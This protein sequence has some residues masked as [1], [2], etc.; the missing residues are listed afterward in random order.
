MPLGLGEV[1]LR[2]FLPEHLHDVLLRE[3]FEAG[4]KNQFIGVLI[5][6][7]DFFELALALQVR[8]VFEAGD[9]DGPILVEFFLQQFPL[10]FFLDSLLPF[11][12][13]FLLAFLFLFGLGV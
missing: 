3:V 13:Q 9:V 1:L 6:G 4:G 12:L 10:H 7:G 11:C 8:G 2:F 5:G